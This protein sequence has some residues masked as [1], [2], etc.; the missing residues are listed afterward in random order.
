MRVAN[1]TSQHACFGLWGPRARDIL[2][3]LTPADLSNDAFPYMTTQSFTVEGVPVR[4]LRVTYVGELGWELYCPS[5]FGATL[6]SALWEAGQP[7]GLVA[8][9]YKAIDTL[10][11]EKGYLVWGADITPDETPDEAGLGF[12]VKVDK[13]GGFIGRQALVEARERGPRVKLACLTLEDPRSVAL[14]N[15]PV[16]IGGEIAGRVT[17]G[18]YGFTVGSSIAFAYLPP[19][20]AA[21][22][23]EVAVE[24]FGEWIPG[25]VAQA[26]LF[27]PKGERI[28]G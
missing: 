8:A 21:P 6:W 3:P 18:G 5:E 17:T 1:V 19:E 23:T 4:A 15:E 2:A 14:G 22:G 28:R 7:H 10:R 13:P 26:P 20:H 24:I 25:T 11:L 9:G 12:A 27:D 16:R